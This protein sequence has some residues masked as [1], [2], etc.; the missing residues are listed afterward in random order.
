MTQS[1]ID[2]LKKKQQVW[3]KMAYLT[4][5]KYLPNLTGE[6]TRII[7]VSEEES[8]QTYIFSVPSHINPAIK[9]TVQISV[10]AALDLSKTWLFYGE[11]GNMD[12][13]YNWQE[14]RWIPMKEI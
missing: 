14:N 9:I 7:G 4:A 8:S 10:I 2:E 12:A 3:M 1:E 5:R 13:K 11:P 6:P